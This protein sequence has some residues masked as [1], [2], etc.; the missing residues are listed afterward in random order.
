VARNVGPS[1]IDLRN[2]AP[3]SRREALFALETVAALH[4]QGFVTNA[5]GAVEIVPLA[6]ARKG[7]KPGQ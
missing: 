2:R 4:G 1:R 5:A 3:L 7:I 6:E